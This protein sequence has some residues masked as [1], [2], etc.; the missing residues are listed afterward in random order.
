M[1]PF[2]L[3][4]GGGDLASGVALRLHRVGLHVLVVEKD[5]PLAVRRSV[6]FAQAV[7]D[8]KVSIE[9]VTGRLIESPGEMASCWKKGEVPVIV[10]PELELLEDYPPLVLV[11]AR[12]R[13]KQVDL[14]L[15]SA[16]L[17]VG[18]G[19]GFTAGEN[20]HAAVETNRGHYLGRVY[21]E[22]SPE[23]DTGVPG[24]VQA[25]A[26]ERVLHAPID[27]IVETL[28]EI[29]DTVE[30]GVP[31]LAVNGLAVTAPF[32]GV[33][34]GLIHDGLRVR[35][36]M[37][38]GDVDPRQETFRCWF[39]SEKSLAIGGGVLEAILTKDSIR[40]HLWGD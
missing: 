6:A 35:K 31:V 37:K 29:G 12:M 11:E 25:Y 10:D 28:V 40:R 16:D 2:V 30:E 24:K 39:V 26:A 4:W 22:G 1:T 18:L 13:K 14:A 20:C 3:I 27:G 32:R 8:D 15:D 23:A 36:G 34:R 17:V 38:V 9:D 19:P 7:F 5:Q 33:V 21:W